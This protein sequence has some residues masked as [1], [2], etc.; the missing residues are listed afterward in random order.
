M[1]QII[2]RLSKHKV[3]PV[4]AVDKAEDILP[5]G[6]QLQANG[7]PVAEITYR[8]DA[9]SKAIELLREAYP[10]MLIGA[11]TVLNEK[12]VIAAKQAGADFI[13]SPG[14]NPNTV[15][16]CQ[17]H[18][19][20]IIPG[21]NNPSTAEQAIELGLD[22]VK[23]FPAEPSGGIAMLKS[24]LAPYSMLKIMPTGGINAKNIQSYLDVTGVVA[25]GGSWMVDKSLINSGKWEELGELIADIV[26][27]LK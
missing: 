15:R 23:F 3:V 4:I 5:L 11:G 10:D 7:L 22:T 21:V 16:A 12:Q 24:L 18:N 9:A 14:L 26:K 19:I 27:Q 20:A 2:E 17:K 8:S 25:C 13:V 6:E 1:Q